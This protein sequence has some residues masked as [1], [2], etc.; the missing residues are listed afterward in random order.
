MD[1]Y[2]FFSMEKFFQLTWK[3]QQLHKAISMIKAH[4]NDQMYYNR[5]A[6]N[7]KLTPAVVKNVLLMNSI[8]D[9]Q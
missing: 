3:T 9:S 1:A 2:C 5:R 4:D 7:T 8:C 6:I